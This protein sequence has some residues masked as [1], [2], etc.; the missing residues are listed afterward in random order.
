MFERFRRNGREEHER[1]GVATAERPREATHDRRDTDVRDG[2]ETQVRDRR[3]G[4]VRDGR[5]E[6][7]VHDDR[8]EPAV[9]DRVH[10]RDKFGGINWGAAFFGWLVAVGL[11][12][13]LVALVSAAGA[14]V[15][16][17]SFSESEARGAAEEISLAGGILLTAI[18]VLAYFAGG[19][20]AG[21]MS[22][23]DGGRQGVAVW[24]IGLLVTVALA[25]AGLVGGSEYN[26]FAGLDLPRIPVDEGSL[27]TGGAIALA[28]IVLGTLLAALF[29]GK[30]GHRYHR[31]V[32]RAAFSPR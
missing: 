30:A 17:T 8:R 18:L 6:R 7:V 28:V 4:D 25:V 24:V 13:L 27:A 15:G 1:G 26:V 19:Y 21:R 16:L 14:A 31:R 3:D 12:V 9:G 10:A 20:V 22:R 29:G 2:G 11:S 32:D 23:F 5:E